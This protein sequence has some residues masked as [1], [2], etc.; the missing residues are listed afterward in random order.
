M[1]MRLQLRILETVRC[2]WRP[3]VRSL[4]E[5]ASRSGE[6]NSI[7][8]WDI[9]RWAC[10]CDQM[11]HCKTDYMRQAVCDV[12]AACFAEELIEA[13][14]NAKVILSNR[15]VDEWYLY[16]VWENARPPYL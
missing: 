11:S 8:Y 1:A 15:D 12:P 5:R 3:C 9:A 4:T 14:P 6:Q 10:G 13:Y 2:G 7:S 16:V